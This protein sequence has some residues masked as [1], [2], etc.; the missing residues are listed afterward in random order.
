[1]LT[2]AGSR[3]AMI[4]QPAA[5]PLVPMVRPM[6]AARVGM[7]AFHTTRKMQ[8]LPAGPRKYFPT[9]Y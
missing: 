1:M 3:P 5:S 4:R 2:A 9:I 8:I 7:T 6:L